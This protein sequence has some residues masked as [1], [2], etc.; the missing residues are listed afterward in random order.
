MAYEPNHCSAVATFLG[1]SLSCA[2]YNRVVH[3]VEDDSTL[4]AT[5]AR[6]LESGG[7]S[8]KQYRSGAELL[9]EDRSI[10]DG[11]ILFDVN[12]PDLDGFAVQRALAERGIATP[13]ILMTGSGD[14]TLLALKAGA[15]DFMQKPFDR[16]ELLSVLADIAAGQQRNG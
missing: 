2:V 8:V 6:I 3:L 16:G 5:L 7:Y 1:A 9:G 4:R 10:E 15:A 13:V 12:M 11:C 14:L